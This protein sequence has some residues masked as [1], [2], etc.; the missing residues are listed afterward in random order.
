ME[1]RELPY[2]RG[3]EHRGKE[4]SNDESGYGQIELTV[5]AHR[6]GAFWQS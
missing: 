2:R 3:S 1:I 6:L 4:Q 5:M